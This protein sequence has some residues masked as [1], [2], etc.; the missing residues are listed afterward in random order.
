MRRWIRI[1]IL[2]M[3]LAVKS[4]LDDVGLF[5]LSKSFF[6]SHTEAFWTVGNRLIFDTPSWVKRMS[7]SQNKKCVL[8]TAKPFRI[9][10]DIA[11]LLLNRCNTR[12]F[13]WMSVCVKL[14]LLCFDCS[15]YCSLLLLVAWC[16][17]PCVTMNVSNDGTSSWIFHMC[18]YS[19]W[20][21]SRSSQTIQQICTT[22]DIFKKHGC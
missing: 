14:C 2:H 4:Y 22:V 5:D 18:L 3:V 17:L 6:W 15:A 19:F 21:Y 9:L 20:S 10:P 7:K 8:R 12:M 1:E 13:L 16:L 11:N